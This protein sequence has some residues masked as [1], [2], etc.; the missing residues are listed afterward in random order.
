MVSW[1]SCGPAAWA[2]EPSSPAA[3]APRGPL[4]GGRNPCP[5]TWNPGYCPGHTALGDSPGPEAPCLGWRAEVSSSFTPRAQVDKASAYW[6]SCC[7]WV[8]RRKAAQS[9]AL[10]G[11]RQAERCVCLGPRAPLLPATASPSNACLPG[12]CGRR[13][14]TPHRS[15]WPAWR[16]W[17]VRHFSDRVAWWPLAAGVLGMCGTA[18][19]PVARERVPE[20]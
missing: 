17:P 11:H 4:C 2:R 9:W 15:L 20:R 8:S 3:P 12:V 13:R 1:P 10:A 7:T 5:Q 16:D 14:G 6:L 19:G 18:Q